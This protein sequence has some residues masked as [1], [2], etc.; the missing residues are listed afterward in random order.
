MQQKALLTIEIRLAETQ[1]PNHLGYDT[2]TGQML[3]GVSGT[4]HFGIDDGQGRRQ[5]ITADVMIK[6]D[7]IDA[8]AVGMGNLR[9]IGNAAIDGDHQR[10]LV[11]MS[12][13]NARE[14]HA[15]RIVTFGQLIGNIQTHAP[16]FLDQQCSAGNTIHIAISDDAHLLPFCNRF[17]DAV[18]HLFHVIEEEGVVQIGKLLLQKKLYLF[19]GCL[20]SS[21]QNGG[22]QYIQSVL[23]MQASHLLRADG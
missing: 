6:D 11:F 4:R 3:E 15:I 18:D 16:Q 9:K 20:T 13:V 12:L 23:L 21:C 19:A 5:G 22:T 8:E 10:D 1:C 14:S 17:I 7:R 2:T